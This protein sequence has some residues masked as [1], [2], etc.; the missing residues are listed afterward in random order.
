MVGKTGV[1][2][3]LDGSDAGEAK[4]M[5]AHNPVIIRQVAKFGFDLMFSGHTQGGQVKLKSRRM[6][7]GLHRRYETQV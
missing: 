3:A 2:S 6:R 5:P 1:R 7:N 4:L